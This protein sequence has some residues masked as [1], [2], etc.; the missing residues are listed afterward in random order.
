MMPSHKSSP[1][2]AVLLVLRVTLLVVDRGALLELPLPDHRHREL[3]ALLAL[4]L[5]RL[6][7]EKIFLSRRKYLDCLGRGR[8]S[9]QQHRRRKIPPPSSSQNKTE[10]YSIC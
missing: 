6:S 10:N 4:D 3:A 9:Q 7:R 2:L 8:V 1:D 5:T